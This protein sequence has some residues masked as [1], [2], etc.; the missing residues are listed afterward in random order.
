MIK[1]KKGMS[2]LEVLIT[3]S[4]VAAIGILVAVLMGRTLKSYRFNQ[5]TVRVQDK[6]AAVMRE[7]ESVARGA[8]EVITADS[9]QFEFF[10]YLAGDAHPAPSKIRY[11]YDDGSI[12]KGR[13]AP[14]GEGPNYTYPDQDEEFETLSEDIISSDL[15]NYY[16]DVNFDYD[17][18]ETTLLDDPVSTTAVR[19]ASITVSCDKDPNQVPDVITETTLV[20]LR[21]LKNNL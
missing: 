19:M 4:F 16:S 8:T 2:L 20:S 13:V 11:F 18:P 17:N 10:T 5:E 15:F 1:R 12:V 6:V 21:N 7:F 3:I 14:S 9:S